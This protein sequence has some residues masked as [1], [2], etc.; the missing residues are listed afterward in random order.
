MCD[1][2]LVSSSL[3]RSLHRNLDMAL[4]R[5]RGGSSLLMFAALLAGAGLAGAQGFDQAAPAATTPLSRLTASGRAK[6]YV[7]ALINP[8]SFVES[9]ASAGFGQWRDRPP[10]WRQGAAGY[11]RRFASSFAQHATGETLKFG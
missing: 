11:G 4:M 3:V 8:F 1:S 7:S 10:E 6:L 9:A 2:R 5:L